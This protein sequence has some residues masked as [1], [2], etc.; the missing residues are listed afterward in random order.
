MKAPHSRTSIGQFSAWFD[1]ETTG[2]DYDGGL[3][4]T[5]RK[6]QGIS[7]GIVIADNRTFEE[8]DALYLEIK[9]DKNKYQ[10]TEGA[11]KIHGLSR[12]HLEKNGVPRDEALA[13]IIEFLSKYFGEN[14][15][16]LTPHKPDQKVCIGGHNVS[17]DIKMIGQIFE[18]FGFNLGIHHVILDTTAAA[19]L[20]VG[21]YKSNDVFTYFGAEKRE[22]HNAL[23]DARQSLAV[24]RGIHELVQVAVSVVEAA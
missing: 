14:I 23:E 4:G 1:W 24:A 12:E 11:E 18:D 10:W 7:V 22:Q 16:C 2:V 21:L 8:V 17:F 9:F 20:A 19:F 6:Y 15:V 3:D 13:S 5:A